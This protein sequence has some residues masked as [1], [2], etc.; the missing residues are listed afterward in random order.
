MRLLLDTNIV[1]DFLNKREPY[2]DAARLLMLCG[3]VGEFELWI[4][5]NQVTDIVY[6]A[7][8][9]GR[10][11]LWPGVSS[12]LQALRSFVKVYATRDNEIDRMLTS[13]WEDPED[14]LL[15]EVALAC[16]M[17][18]IITR[19][20]SDYGRS[21]IK[22]CDANEFFDWMREDFNRDYAEIAFP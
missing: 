21:I 6:I 15:Y 22:V 1:I 2:Y 12:Q 5:S 14:A 19:N 10:K 16:N 7:T 3:K 18:A 8:D 13:E 20:Q 4:A 11:D 9:G 17:G